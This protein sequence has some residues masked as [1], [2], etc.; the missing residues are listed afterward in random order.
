MEPVESDGTLMGIVN[1][2]ILRL[3]RRVGAFQDFLDLHTFV[4]RPYCRNDSSCSWWISLEEG[5][6]DLDYVLG[7][8]IRNLQRS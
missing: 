7:E 2:R 4:P 1:D 3:G 8:E 5:L 6:M